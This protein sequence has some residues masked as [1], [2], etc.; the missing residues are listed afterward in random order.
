VAGCSVA[1]QPKPE[2]GAEVF[3]PAEDPT[4]R[5]TDYVALFGA[6]VQILASAVTIAVVV[7][8]L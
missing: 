7:T 1:E 4:A 2:P 3:V 5:K 8:K 6:I